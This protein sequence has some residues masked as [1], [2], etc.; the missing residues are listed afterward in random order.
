MVDVSGGIWVPHRAAVF[1]V[2]ADQTPIGI[3]LD[4]L[5]NRFSVSFNESK[6]ASCLIDYLVDVCLPG[7][8]I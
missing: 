8:V 6:F 4:G 3:G 5:G 1:K 7:E 2:W